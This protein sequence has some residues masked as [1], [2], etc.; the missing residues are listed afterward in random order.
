MLL[1][2]DEYGHFMAVL[3][4]FGIA[5][6]VSNPVLGIMTF[7]MSKARGASAAYAAPEVFTR[8]RTG[9]G[10]EHPDLKKAADIYAFG[11]STHEFINRQQP[12]NNT[13]K[14][15]T[16]IEKAVLDG[17]RPQLSDE[18]K[19]KKENDKTLAFLCSTMELCWLQNAAARP[20][21]ESLS[22]TFQAFN[23]YR[24]IA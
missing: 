3:C 12:W 16:D 8:L 20:T 9:K 1:E 4:D 7:G 17:L 10:P 13:L 5:S 11:I 6:I 19:A 23:P 22:K 2:K 24:P 21:A 14:K 15:S 18:I